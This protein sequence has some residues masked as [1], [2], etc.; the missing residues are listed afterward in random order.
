[1]RFEEESQRAASL[2][3]DRRGGDVS[4]LPFHR[5]ISLLSDWKASTAEN[6]HRECPMFKIPY[7][8]IVQDRE[9]L[10]GETFRWLFERSP[11]GNARKSS[12]AAAAAAATG[13]WEALSEADSE[14]IEKAAQQGK[15]TVQLC[16]SRRVSLRNMTLSDN[17]EFAEAP[18]RLRRDPP[19]ESQVFPLPRRR[20]PASPIDRLTTK[21]HSVVPTC[22]D[23]YRIYLAKDRLRRGFGAEPQLPRV[24]G[25][26]QGCASPAPAPAEAAWTVFE[27]RRQLRD[28]INVLSDS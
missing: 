14:T 3:M 20:V 9:E 8:L 24:S 12:A 21:Y 25:R 11:A 10:A 5:K 27:G 15:E 7:R 17:L 1:M 23:C 4:S 6:R 22:Q 18:L 26:S 2:L 28:L 13:V 16:R 19:L